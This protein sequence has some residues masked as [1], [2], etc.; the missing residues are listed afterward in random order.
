LLVGLGILF[1][2]LRLVYDIVSL[3]PSYSAA[4]WTRLTTPTSP[5]YHTLWAPVL[6]G[7]LLGN[8]LF[9][10]LSVLN[11]VL[12]L[13]K[14]RSFPWFFIAFLVT[15]TVFL[16]ADGALAAIVAPKTDNA[17]S[18]ADLARAII[19]VSIWVP[20]FLASK[21]VKATFRN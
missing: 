6:I 4:T 1:T 12:F 10:G 16:L 3:V 21:R 17:G 20:Y 11:V 2:P 9:L 19:A 14:R 5:D 15:N 18:A 7:E 13:Q 8:A